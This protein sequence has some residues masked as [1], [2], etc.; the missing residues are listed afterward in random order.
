MNLWISERIVLPLAWI[1]FAGVW[2]YLA[3]YIFFTYS[4]AVSA[5]IKTANRLEIWWLSYM[6]FCLPN[7]IN[8]IY[9]GC[10]KI[11]WTHIITPSRNFVEVRWRSLF[12]S[13][14]LGKRITSYNAPSTS[15]KRAADSWSLRNFLPRSS[16]FMVGKAQK[17]HG[18]RSGLYGGCSN[19]VL[20]IHF[21][22]AEHRSWLKFFL[23]IQS[24]AWICK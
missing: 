21:F 11:S 15:W 7:I 5:G 14:S 16:F 9:V 10:F 2:F 22:Q 4:V 12:R 8:S 19:G 1:S 18:A 3:F 24:I 13:T 6:H 23:P 17:S 20:P